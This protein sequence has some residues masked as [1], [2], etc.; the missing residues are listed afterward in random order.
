MS[1]TFSLNLS[2]S[3]DLSNGTASTLMHTTCETTHD[4]DNRVYFQSNTIL[5]CLEPCEVMSRL[6]WDY[7]QLRN[8]V[9]RQV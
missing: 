6:P 8:P 3:A 4:G 7:A 2:L 9:P 5:S 1:S